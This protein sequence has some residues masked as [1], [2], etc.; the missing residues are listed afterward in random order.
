[1][2][3]DASDRE[4]DPRKFEARRRMRRNADGSQTEVVLPPIDAGNVWA[5]ATRTT[6]TAR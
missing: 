6:T 1:M 2:T 4:Y 5:G 3:P